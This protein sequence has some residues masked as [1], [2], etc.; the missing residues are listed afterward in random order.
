M[1]TAKED[2]FYSFL[3]P[4]RNTKDYLRECLNSILIQQYSNFEVIIVDNESN[5]G[6][7]KLIDAYAEKDSRVRVIHQKNAGLLMSR[8][9][10]ISQA[11]G[12][13]V[14][15][16]DSD[17]FIV[18]DYLSAIHTAVQKTEPDILLIGYQLVDEQ[19]NL[20]HDTIQIMPRTI[21]D[22]E[23]IQDFSVL[24]AEN[25]IL[26]N[27]WLKVAKRSLFDAQK[28]NGY[29]NLG[30]MNGVEGLIQSVEILERAKN[31]CSIYQEKLY[32][33][34]IREGSTIRNIDAAS[35][36]KEYRVGKESLY[37]LAEHYS[38]N[39]QKKVEEKYFPVEVF[40]AFMIVRDILSSDI[41][42]GAK[43]K[44]LDAVRKDLWA[45]SILDR[46]SS[47][48]SRREMILWL[49]RCKMYFAA[50]CIVSAVQRLGGVG[51]QSNNTV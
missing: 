47:P 7:E 34:R 16:V 51:D 9:V 42:Y 35:R 13:Y 10:A 39:V 28:D 36:L 14:C 2:I 6:S 24:M 15:F 43:C 23:N 26:N 30:Q 8:R 44:Q 49:I 29:R 37:H 19:S 4:V 5:D 1:N 32:C 18:P 46:I 33:Y 20:L 50:Y 3:V 38:L 21:Y 48:R 31:I 12:D 40:S 22:S 25:P 41:A 17:D 11:T 45:K 27:L